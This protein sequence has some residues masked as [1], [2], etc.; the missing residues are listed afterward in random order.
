MKKSKILSIILAIFLCLS[1]ALTACNC[2]CGGEEEVEVTKKQGIHGGTITETADKFISNGKTD[3]VLVYDKDSED[4]Y[5]ATAKNLFLNFFRE[6]TKILLVE[7]DDSEVTYSED[8]KAIILG[9]N[10]VS[11][12]A[13][14]TNEVKDKA[15]AAFQ[16]KT[17]GKSIFILGRSYGAVYGGEE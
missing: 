1:T 5:I 10:T 13:G 8:L 7:K 15:E 3:F 4:E 6:A 17:K 9:E 16:L 14:L 11:E 12:A 2:N